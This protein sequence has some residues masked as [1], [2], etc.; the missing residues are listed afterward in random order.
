MSMPRSATQLQRLGL[1]ISRD[2]RPI[3]GQEIR[4]GPLGEFFGYGETTVALIQVT[5]TLDVLVVLAES[6]VVFASRPIWWRRA[7]TLSQAVT[8]AYL[9]YFGFRILGIR[10]AVQGIDGET[11]HRVSNQG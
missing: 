9:F 7:S 2:H 8:T 4:I 11:I 5:R 1:E 6:S 10:I 3:L